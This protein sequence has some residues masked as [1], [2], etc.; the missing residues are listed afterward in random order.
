MDTSLGRPTV[1]VPRRL[2][3]LFSL[4]TRTD[5]YNV[6]PMNANHLYAQHHAALQARYANLLADQPYDDLIIYSGQPVLRFR[7]DQAYPFRADPYYQQWI[8]A[9]DHAGSLILV[10]PGARPLAVCL[11]PKDYWHVVPESPAGAWT[12]H[13]DLRVAHTPGEVRTHL[14]ADLSN[15]AAVGAGAEAVADWGVAALNPAP[16][17]AAMDFL[18]VYKTDYEIDCLAAAN[19]IAARGHV[20]ARNAFMEGRSEHGIHLAYL[21]ATAHMEAELPYNNIVA[22]NEHAATLHYD[23]LDRDPPESSR[24]FLIDAGATFNGYAADITRTSA[25]A[26]G[27]FADLVEAMDAAQRR[28][29]TRIRSGGS[30]VNLHEQAHLEIAAVLGGLGIVR[31]APEDMVG[32]G[33]TQAFFPHGLG[34]HLGLQVHDAGGKLADP[35]GTLVDQ[36]AEHPFLRNLRPI[37]TGNVLTIEPGLYFIDQ[38]LSPLRSDARGADVDWELVDR[39]SPFGGVRIEDDVVVTS[40]GIVNLTRDAFSQTSG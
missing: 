8:P 9:A 3:P 18:R 30:Y 38:L 17:L 33:I 39:F 21:T 2:K 37:E 20:A 19:A 15:V 22:L 11:L 36:P 32:R 6:Y 34:H 24:S 4:A 40:D 10:R 25:R 5:L 16:L 35:T 29:L 12:E 28:I 23:R 31:G 27:P 13:F 14:P 1:W 26:P 7:D